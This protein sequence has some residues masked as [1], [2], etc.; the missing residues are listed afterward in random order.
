V[1]GIQPTRN[2]A[3]NIA[4]SNTLTTSTIA[5]ASPVVVNA[6][7]GN[8]G[9]ASIKDSGITALPVPALPITLTYNSATNQF[10]YGA[11]PTLVTYT[12]GTP[13][14][15]AGNAFVTLTGMPA[16]G[17]V[18]TIGANTNGVADNR[19]ALLLAKLQTANTMGGGTTSYQGSYSQMVSQVG[20]K[21]AEVN[22]TL[23]AQQNLL[24]Q[25]RN[26]Q[27]ALSG[28]NLD[29]EAANLLKYQ[30]AYQAAG[31]M[32]QIANNM[33]DTLLSLAK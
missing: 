14:T 22:V 20:N 31:K 32:M 21:A 9:T 25:S 24:T 18:F 8:T 27:Q 13:M 23:Q 5:A 28:V 12:P 16:N 11:G 17:D 19:N 3:Q 4:L 30:Q 33:F 6:S 2:G 7:T 29:E 1:F 26:S 10:S 15:I